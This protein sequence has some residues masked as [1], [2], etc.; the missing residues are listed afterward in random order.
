MSY[1]ETFLLD[2]DGDLVISELKKPE[3]VTGADKVPQDLSVLLNMHKGEHPVNPDFGV[4]WLRIKQTGKN[5]QVITAE[6]TRALKLYNW[7]KS[8]EDITIG[9]IDENRQLPITIK[10]VTTEDE[11]IT[12][13]V[14]A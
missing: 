12:A 4:E 10:I 6:I 3:I 2:S 9:E 7:F 8:L 13:G 14:A 1:R 11:V 5:D